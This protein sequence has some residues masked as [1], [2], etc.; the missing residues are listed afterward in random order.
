M[1]KASIFLF[2]DRM[3][4]YLG[5]WADGRESLVKSELEDKIFSFSECLLCYISNANCWDKRIPSCCLLGKHMGL[6]E[7][8]I[9]G[10]KSYLLNE[11][12]EDLRDA[13]WPLQGARQA[14]SFVS[15]RIRNYE[16]SVTILLLSSKRMS[17]RSENEYCF[18]VSPRHCSSEI[19][20]PSLKTC[21]CYLR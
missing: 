5:I 4:Q 1:G 14:T 7:R 12:R 3:H 11:I 6:W 21:C 17:C 8:A 16:W 9:L 2:L 10:T 15:Q 18:V 13:S 19:H 20:M